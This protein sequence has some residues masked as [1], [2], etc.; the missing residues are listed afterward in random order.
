MGNPPDACGRLPWLASTTLNEVSMWVRYRHMTRIPS[1]SKRPHSA[2]GPRGL[3]EIGSK[4]LARASRLL[5]RHL[6]VLP[7]LTDRLP[8][9][10]SPSR[11]HRGWGIAEAYRDDPC[12]CV[13][14]EIA[15]IQTAANSFGT[16][17]LTHETVSAQMMRASLFANAT[18]TRFDGLSASILRNLG[19]VISLPHLAWRTTWPRS[20]G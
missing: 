7:R 10:R 14:A 16:R 19:S 6:V 15:P 1:R 11:L 13:Y 8:L 4:S 20:T 3:P 12:S 18:S 17:Q 2:A 5:V 9:P